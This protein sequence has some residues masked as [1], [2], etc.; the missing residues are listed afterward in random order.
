MG[1]CSVFDK[2]IIKRMSLNKKKE[3]VEIAKELS[4]KLRKEQT[5]AEKIFWQSVRN[6]KFLN[7]KFYRQYPIFH[8]I[9]G[10]ETF[11]IADF[12]CH[13]ERLVVEIDGKLHQYKVEEDKD[14]TEILRDLGLKVIRFTNDEIEKDIEGVLLRLKN[15]IEK[16]D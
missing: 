4:R 11:F 6:K 16:K 13:E 1:E 7:K 2:F 3:L 12:Y 14:R 9:T 5:S 15:F 8:D 10:R